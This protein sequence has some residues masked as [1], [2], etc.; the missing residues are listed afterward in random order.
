M[1][2]KKLTRDEKIAKAYSMRLRSATFEEIGHE[3]DIAKSTAFEYVK[4]A[5]EK[6]DDYQETNLNHLRAIRVQ[7]LELLINSRFK[8]LKACVDVE[9]PETGRLERDGI[10]GRSFIVNDIAKLIQE[11][12]KLQGLYDTEK[13]ESHIDKKELAEDIQLDSM[14]DDDLMQLLVDY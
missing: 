14:S 3:L 4:I 2:A 13:V 8:D 10:R 11:L 1:D 9:N 12:C 6:Y 7:Q 5:K